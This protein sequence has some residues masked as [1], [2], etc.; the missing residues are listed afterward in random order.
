MSSFCGLIPYVDEP[1]NLKKIVPCYP[2]L[3]QGIVLARDSPGR[4]TRGKLHQ[5][6]SLTYRVQIRKHA[7]NIR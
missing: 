6:K 2:S 7:Y 1:P 4:K 5:M 3:P